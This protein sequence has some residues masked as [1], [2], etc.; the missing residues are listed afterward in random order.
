M[1]IDD[2]RDS[3]TETVTVSFTLANTGSYAAKEILQLYVSAPESTIFKPVRELR[4]FEAVSLVPGE[5]RRITM[6]LGC[7]AFSYY[8]V[9]LH[10][11][12]VEEGT[13]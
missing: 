7:R 5:S 4:A 1:S 9:L 10:V 6:T 8:N 2:V 11:W 12:F 3:E 13:Y